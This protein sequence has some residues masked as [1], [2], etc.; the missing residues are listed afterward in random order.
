MKESNFTKRVRN[1]LIMPFGLMIIGLV[2]A[3]L[4]G[5]VLVN[6][7]SLK[8]QLEI[9]YN[10]KFGTDFDYLGWV[11]IFEDFTPE[12]SKLVY[13]ESSEDFYSYIE[14][15][16][17]IEYHGS[18]N[19]DFI[20]KLSALDDPTYRKRQKEATLLYDKENGVICNNKKVY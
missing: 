12:S 10:E 8:S 6:G 17:F 19:S 13:K 5:C 16:T 4:N 9:D 7:S 18:F 1:R 2:F 11:E 15:S 3:L 20:I 14:E